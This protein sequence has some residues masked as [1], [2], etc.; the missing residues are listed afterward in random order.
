M[1]NK[2][3]AESEGAM[4]ALAEKIDRSI[5]DADL[6]AGKTDAAMLGRIKRMPHLATA[7][8][9]AEKLFRGIDD[10]HSEDGLGEIASRYV[11]N[12]AEM[13]KMRPKFPK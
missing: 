5:T 3:P 11:K 7:V 12:K 6:I 1:P 9:L 4:A 10:I 2:S 8:E 13:E